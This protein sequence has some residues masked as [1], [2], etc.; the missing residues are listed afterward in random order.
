MME[1]SYKNY[2]ILYKIILCEFLQ[3]TNKYFL[4]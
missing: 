2:E 1:T 3:V 4:K